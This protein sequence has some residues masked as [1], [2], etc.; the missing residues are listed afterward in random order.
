LQGSGDSAG[1]QKT[2]PESAFRGILSQLSA[3]MRDGKPVPARLSVIEHQ[4]RM[5]SMTQ[6]IPTLAIITA[7]GL[8]LG[9]T[10]ASARG[11]DRPAL[12]TFEELDTQKKGAVTLEDMQQFFASRQGARVDEMVASLMKQQSG[13]DEAALRAAIEG[14]MTE[15]RAEAG[16]KMRRG[17]DTEMGARMFQRIDADK[18][19]SVTAEEYA[20]FAAKVSD[21]M[22]NRRDGRRGG[23]HGRGG[24]H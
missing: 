13:L 17:D 20:A 21:R 24:H 9:I 23:E 8:G 18:D 7:L 5:F 16:N 11:M 14:M 15:R 22:E 1:A 2:H 19:G 12:P 6:T 3:Q 10:S 4:Q